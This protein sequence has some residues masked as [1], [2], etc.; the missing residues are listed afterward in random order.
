M[1][2]ELQFAMFALALAVSGPALAQDNKAS[3]V[4]AWR[5]TSLQF[6]NSEGSLAEVPY[7]GQV[8]FSQSGSLSVQAMDP[9]PAAKPTTY[10]AHGYEAYYG[11]VE[12]D[13][14][15]NTFTITVESSLVRDLIGQKL[16]RKF[17][18]TEDQLVILPADP[19]EGWRVTYE[20]F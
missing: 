1:K 20:R 17:Q 4:G 10:T 5:M 15:K 12:I 9:D 13:E 14:A 2:T 18:V 8:I 16:V 11:P 7:S 6:T 19:S 3:I